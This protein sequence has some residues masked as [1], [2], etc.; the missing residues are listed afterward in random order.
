M[1]IHK[2]DVPF[3]DEI[4]RLAIIKLCDLQT[5]R[6]NTMKVKLIR[7]TRFLDVTNT[8]LLIFSK[9]RP[10]GVVDLRSIGYYKVKQSIILLCNAVVSMVYRSFL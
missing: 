6:T 9:D 10:L 1:K 8:E 5:G 4:S 2:I 3:I 7:K